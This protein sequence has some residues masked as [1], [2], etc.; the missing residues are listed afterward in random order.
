MTGVD[1]LEYVQNAL[2]PELP[3]RGFIG[4]INYVQELIRSGK[5]WTFDFGTGTIDTVAVFDTGTVAVTLG[6]T[7]ATGTGTTFTSAME[8]RKIRINRIPYLIATRNSD[9]EILLSANYP[10]DTDTGLS[11]SVYQDEYALAS[12]VVQVIRLWDITNRRRLHA[13]PVQTLG[14]RDFLRDQS[15][16]SFR[17]GLFGVNSSGD[18]LLRFTP[19]PDSVDRFEYWYEKDYTRVTAIGG[20]IDIPSELDFVVKQ[21]CLARVSAQLRVDERGVEMASFTKLLEGA[22]LKDRALMD[23][24]VRLMRS[25]RPRAD[26]EVFPSAQ[27][28]TTDP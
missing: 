3:V 10:A 15:G 11:F 4:T 18:R 5:S 12:D 22:Y 16:D 20:T 24:K 7:T 9:T 1:A 17:Y 2:P 26:I 6:S 8:G 13:T 21:G 19:W 27:T 25:D 23:M 14:D 28:I